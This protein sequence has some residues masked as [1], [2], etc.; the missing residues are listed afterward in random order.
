MLYRKSVGKGL[1]AK[2][3]EEVR[4]VRIK[5]YLFFGTSR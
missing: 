4:N 2:V 3:M 5:N 1:H